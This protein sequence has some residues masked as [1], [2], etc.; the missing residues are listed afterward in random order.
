MELDK[1][2]LNFYTEEEKSTVSRLSPFDWIILI[3][4]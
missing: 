4:L 3:I 1:I 2:V